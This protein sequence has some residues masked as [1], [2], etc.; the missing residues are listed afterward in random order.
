MMEEAID[1]P[2]MLGPPVLADAAD[3]RALLEVLSLAFRD[4]PMNVRI[5]GPRPARRVRANRAGLRALVLDAD[6]E[7]LALVVHHG[8]EVVGGFVAV[9]P[10]AMPLPPPRWTRLLGCLIHQGPRAMDEWGQVSRDMGAYRPVLPH[11]YLAVLGVLPTWQGRGIGGR[12]LSALVDRARQDAVPIYLESDRS[13][14]VGF[15]RARG[16]SDCGQEQVHGVV[17]WCLRH[18][19]GD[20]L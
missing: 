15:Y 18:D 16:F 12:L 19:S 6:R 14:S 10:G 2:V 3:R 1:Q 17:C 8:S 9:P 20:A 13:E 5:H 4:N 7:T 11:W